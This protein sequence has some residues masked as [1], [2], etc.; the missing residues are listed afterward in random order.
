MFLNKVNKSGIIYS[1]SIMNK[2]GRIFVEAGH[3]DQVDHNEN[4]SFSDFDHFGEENNRNPFRNTD[5]Q[6]LSNDRKHEY[7]NK[8][9]QTTSTV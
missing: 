5:L 2:R 1:H 7:I 4:D 8:L 6:N 9:N 3:Q